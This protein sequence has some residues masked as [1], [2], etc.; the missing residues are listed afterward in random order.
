M[1]GSG[2]EITKELRMTLALKTAKADQ[3]ATE[4]KLGK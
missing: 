3:E 1:K 4:H 2:I